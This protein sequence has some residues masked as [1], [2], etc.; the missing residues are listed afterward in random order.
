MRVF[1]YQYAAQLGNNSFLA[2]LVSSDAGTIHKAYI[3]VTLAPRIEPCRTP[4][5]TSDKEAAKPT[6]E[7]MHTI[8]VIF[9]PFQL[10]FIHFLCK[11]AETV[12]YM[13]YDNAKNVQQMA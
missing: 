10:I 11:T 12:V 9:I 2:L 1:F 7:N 3:G 5:R 4:C 6:D 13:L 8:L